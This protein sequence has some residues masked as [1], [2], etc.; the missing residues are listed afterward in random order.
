MGKGWDHTPDQEAYLESEFQHY[1]KAH[2][3]GEVKNWH[4]LLHEKW[5]ECWPEQQVLI[6]K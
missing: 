1:L 5:E 6:N 2:K 4:A 3:D